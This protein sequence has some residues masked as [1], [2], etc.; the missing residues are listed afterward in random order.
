MKKFILIIL[1]CLLIGAIPAHAVIKKVAQTGL[2]FMKVDV[3]TRAA[4]LGGSYTVIGNDASAMFYNPAGIGKMD[5]K[6]EVFVTQ[7]Q[8]IA[9]ITYNAGAV[10]FN[11]GNLGI[12]GLSFI[13][14]DYGEILGTRV[15][16]TEK[17][18]EDTGTLDVGA[19][20]IGLTYAR[21]ITDKFIVGGQIKY[22]YQQLGENRM[23]T[24]GTVSKNEVNGLAYDF[25]TIFYP[26]FKSMRFGMSIRNFSQQ[27]KYRQ[28]G[29]QL[30]LTF[31][32]GVAMDVMD[33]VGEHEN[34]LVVSIDAS[35]PRD[36]TERILI[37]AEYTLF[38]MLSLRGGY[39]MNFDEEGLT[40]GVGFKT[41]LSGIRLDLGYSYSDFGVFDMVNRISVGVA[42]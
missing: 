40:G 19:Y 34:P 21:Q 29:F 41:E 3:G 15:A 2:Q 22:C 26:G 28:E 4:A 9:D 13:T 32:L 14:A 11:A 35:H 31:T 12:F 16:A 39:K 20:A 37:G 6:A 1:L 33:F 5:K 23:N 24:A 10:A 7:T 36:Y 38:N 18:F 25:G 27:F 42:F 17:G 30:P 8:W